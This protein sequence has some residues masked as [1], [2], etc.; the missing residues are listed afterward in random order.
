RVHVDAGR[1]ARRALPVRALDLAAVRRRLAGLQGQQRARSGR[2][3]PAGAP[4]DD[5]R[6]VC[7]LG[8]RAVDL[9]RRE[10]RDP[11]EQA[12]RLQHAVGRERRP[13]PAPR[14]RRPHSLGADRRCD[15]VPG[16]LPRPAP[17]ESVRDDDERRRRARVLHLPFGVRVQRD[18]P[19]AGAGGPRRGQ[20][21]CAVERAARRLVR[22]VEP[23][24]H[25]DEYAAGERRRRADRDRLGQVGEGDRQGAGLRSDAGL[26]LAGLGPRDHRRRRRRLAALPRL[27]RHRPELRQPCLHRSIVGSPAFAPRVSGGPIALP[28]DTAALATAKA[29]KYPGA[30]TEGTALDAVGD[31]V[32]PNEAATG[33]ASG[34]SASSGGSSAGN[35]GSSSSSSGSAGGGGPVAPAGPSPVELWDSGW[36][37]GR[38]YWTV[39]PVTVYETATPDPTQQNPVVPI[40]YQ[41]TAVPQD[42]CQ[43]GDLMSFGKVTPPVVTSSGRPFV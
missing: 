35:T 15:R 37:S 14:S 2:H 26:R 40:G 36:P 33:G 20:S 42:A 19:L 10:Q 16:P 24:L 21:R 38:Y 8:A 9:E 6:P 31:K 3:R 18:H 25:D 27:H 5:G 29:G 43:A 28:A 41:D 12:L 32:T 22:A 11:L 17:A 30:G 4:V 23:D 1:G 7:A 39:V 34:S 13:A